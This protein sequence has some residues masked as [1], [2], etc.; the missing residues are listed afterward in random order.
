MLRGRVP[1]L[2]LPNPSLVSSTRVVSSRHSA[3]AWIVDKLEK[4]IKETGLGISY[5]KKS[6]RSSSKGTHD[7]DAFEFLSCNISTVAVPTISLSG[8]ASSWSVS[9]TVRSYL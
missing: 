2:F 9:L 4:L 1:H 7:E 6:V 8:L 5:P 3:T